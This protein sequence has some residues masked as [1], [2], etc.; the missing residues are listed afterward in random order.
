MRQDKY[1]QKRSPDVDATTQT[2]R[3]VNAADCG[4]ETAR[5]ILALER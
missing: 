1:E 3:F 5:K 4:D 2:N